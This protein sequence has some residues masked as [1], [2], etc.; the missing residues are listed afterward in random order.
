MDIDKVKEARS[1]L[2]DLDVLNEIQSVLEKED[3]H[4]WNLLTPRYKAMG[5]RWY[6]N[7]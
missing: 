3:N 4:W 1:F 5:R 2:C 6:S 7:A